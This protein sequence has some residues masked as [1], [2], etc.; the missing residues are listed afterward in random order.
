MRR[1]HGRGRPSRKSVGPLSGE[2]CRPGDAARSFADGVASLSHVGVGRAG[3][4]RVGEDAII[5]AV[6]ESFNG[7]SR[8]ELVNGW[9]FDDLREARVLIEDW[10]IDDNWKRPYT[11]HGDLTQESSP[12]SGSPNRPKP[13]RC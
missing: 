4:D 12:R 6:I 10:R 8:D 7:T 9:Q 5:D 1:H 3:A 13:H 11:A 2:S